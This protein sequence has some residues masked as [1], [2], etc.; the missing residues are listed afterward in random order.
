MTDQPLSSVELYDRIVAMVTAQAL[1]E[2][3][4]AIE[5]LHPGETKNS[6]IWLRERAAAALGDGPS[7]PST[8]HAQDSSE[9]NW[10]SDTPVSELGID[11]WRCL[12]RNRI[13]TLGDLLDRTVFD[14]LCVRHFGWRSI[15][16]LVADLDR[17]G[18][19]LMPEIETETERF[20]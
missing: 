2:A 14:L 13:Y 17:H 3:A 12:T 1:R 8:D 16:K 20:K 9:P 4:D 15:N 7:G 18:L 5:A 11:R 6:V 10:R 19:A